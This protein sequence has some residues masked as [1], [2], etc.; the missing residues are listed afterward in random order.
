MEMEPECVP[1]LLKRCIYEANL[2]APEKEREVTEESL[3]ILASEFREGVVSSEVATKVHKRVYEILD[4]KDPYAEM[5]EKSNEVAEKLLPRGRVIVKKYGFKGAALVA[6]TGNVMDFGYRDDFDSPEYLTDKFEALI[7]EGFEHD[8][9]ARIE[10]IVDR[11]G[12]VVF[13]TDNCGEIV[14]DIPL[15]EVLKE[16]GVYLTMVVK[17]APVLTDAT[18]EDVKKYNIQNV[19]DE[20]LT[21][22]GFAVGVDLNN[23]PNDLEEALNKADLIIAKGMANWESLSETNY[24]PIAY[25]TR[26]KCG[27]VAR[28]MGVKEEINVAKLFQ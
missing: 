9:T 10:K 1:C 11:G 28:S 6:V 14:L 21:T 19:A 17:G 27:P 5:K 3:N 7:E 12:R 20:I 16:K 4:T 2:V 25:I 22:G 13:F 24:K 18:M 23:M 15:L 26:S 8:D